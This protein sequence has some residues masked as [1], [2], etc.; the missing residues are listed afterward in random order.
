ME[1]KEMNLDFLNHSIIKEFFDIFGEFH[2][3]FQIEILNKAFT[4]R[5]DNT[6]V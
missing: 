5:N 4:F 3:L 2:K 1:L 6:N